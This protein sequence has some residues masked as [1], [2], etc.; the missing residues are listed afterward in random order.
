MQEY[1]TRGLMGAVESYIACSASL[2]TSPIVTHL[3]SPHLTALGF[4]LDFTWLHS[5]PPTA[6][7]TPQPAR[8]L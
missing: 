4:H 7:P 1:F 3:A 2:E 6:P 5:T 8:G